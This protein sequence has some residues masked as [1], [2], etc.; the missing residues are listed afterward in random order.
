MHRRRATSAADWTGTA[1]AAVACR[2]RRDARRLVAALALLAVLAGVLVSLPVAGQDSAGEADVRITARRLAN[3]KV[4]FGLQ[5]RQAD[6][7]W[8]DRLLPATRLF[9]TTAR[10]GAWLVSSPLQLDVADVRITARRLANGKV[11][12]G[13]QQRQADRS[14]GD[15][16]LPATRL[17]PTTARVGTWLV[18]SPLRLTV[19]RSDAFVAVSAGG[20]HTCGLRGDGTVECWDGNFFA[21]L[22]SP[23]GR[24]SAVTSGEFHSC[25]LRTDGTVD[26]WVSLELVNQ[27]DTP[28]GRFSAV[29]AG[30]G[31]TCG[32]RDGGAVECWGNDFDGQSTPPSGSF[33]AVS[34][35]DRHACGLRADGSVACWGQNHA[36]QATPPSGSFTAV[37][38]GGR[39]SCGLRDGGT[40]ECWGDV[41]SGARMGWTPVP[42]TE[43]FATISVYLWHGCGLRTDGTVACWGDEPPWPRPSGRFTAVATGAAH[44]CVLRPDG[45]IECWGGDRWYGRPRPDSP[46]Y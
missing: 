9:P 21:E 36:G 19:P 14:W 17:F 43:R 46:A 40:V 1:G 23:P 45:T 32:V 39:F 34:A 35:G 42:T 31:F 6:R 26:C 29:S 25:G 27:E 10:V 18:S 20:L 16:L 2:V 30:D 38:A 15:R 24:F 41:E 44:A 5:Q 13:L 11:E 12:F 28:S 37:S 7:S 22:G 3:G 8:G 4:E 33:S